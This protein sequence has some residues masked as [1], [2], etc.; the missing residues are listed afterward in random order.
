V[1]WDFLSRVETN[2]WMHKKDSFYEYVGV[3]IDNLF[4][5]SKNPKLIKDAIT[6]NCNFKLKGIECVEFHSSSGMKMGTS[7]LHC[8]NISRRC[9]A[10]M[11]EC[12]ACF[13]RMQHCPFRRE[14]IWSLIS[15]TCWT[16]KGSSST[17]HSALQWV[18]QIG[19]FDIITAVMTM[20]C[21]QAAPRKGHM[22]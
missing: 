15:Q 20:S 3:Y 14:I 18:I 4:I 10:T 19:C 5:I 7:A 6:N 22:D 1:T 13:Q 9:S 12:L 8:G 21:F 17:N 2:I 11:S 16:L